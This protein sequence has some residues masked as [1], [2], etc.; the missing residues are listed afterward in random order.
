MFWKA[1]PVC[2][3]TR[4]SVCVDGGTVWFTG[5]RDGRCPHLLPGP[6]GRAWAPQGKRCF[7]RA[8][9]AMQQDP[10]LPWRLASDCPR[11][12]SDTGVSPNVTVE[13]APWSLRRPLMG[14]F[15][16]LR[17]GC[18]RPAQRPHVHGSEGAG[19]YVLLPW[20]AQSQGGGCSPRGPPSPE[21]EWGAALPVAPALGHCWCPCAF[22]PWGAQGASPGA[23]FGSK[24]PGGEAA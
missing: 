5:E 10:G 11:G 14:F 21:Q 1:G 13:L 4:A 24:R 9:W 20:S 23:T 15:P 19:A 8:A 2:E 17:C 22:S 12:G 18:C 16:R 3:D 6:V 7:L